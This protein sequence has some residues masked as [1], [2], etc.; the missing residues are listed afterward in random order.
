M[1][2]GLIGLLLF[3]VPVLVMSFKLGKS[4]FHLATRSSFF[5]P[6]TSFR[7][8]SSTE[9]QAVGKSNVRIISYNILSS[10]LAEP[11][12]FTSCKP[13]NLDTAN[14]LKK[15]KTKL[16]AEIDQEAIICLQEVSTTW[17]G[18]LHQFFSQNN[19]HFITGLY[20][21]RNNGYMGVAMAVPMK[22][23]EIR[24]A[25]IT[26]VA[27]SKKIPKKSR[28]EGRPSIIQ[29]LMKKITAPVSNKLL[30]T[31]RFL[32]LVGSP[33]QSI[34]FWEKALYRFN[35]MVCCRLYHR[36]GG[37]EFVVGTYHMPCMFDLSS[38]MVAHCSLSAQLI[39]RFSAGLPYFFVGDF[40]IKP[41]SAEYR[42]LTEGKIDPMVSTPLSLSFSL[43]F[44]DL[45]SSFPIF[46]F[47]LI[48]FLLL[49]LSFLFF[50]FFLSTIMNRIPP[51]PR[52]WKEMTGLPTYQLP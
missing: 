39:H 36:E 4:L 26:R 49:L 51:I 15:I 1:R 18:A 30:Q 20:G 5:L 19:Y 11:S 43:L 38:V 9:T 10:N 23:F 8:F 22:S 29:Q 34:D 42:L 7:R 13:E 21:G 48:L 32:N 31:A 44:I 25:N 47:P 52:P 24:D 12:W 28:A 16:K 3:L 14:R 37:A 6:R 40:N 45:I 33:S 46:L 27:D 35:Q 50:F 41:G 17:A 2:I